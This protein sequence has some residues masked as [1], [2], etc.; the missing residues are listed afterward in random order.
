[1]KYYCVFKWYGRNMN[2]LAAEI[3]E[4][5]LIS[6]ETIEKLT[7]D[8]KHKLEEK[9]PNKGPIDVILINWKKID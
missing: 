2:G 1:M 3:Y 6:S 7:L 5:P 4:T 9:Y 8:I